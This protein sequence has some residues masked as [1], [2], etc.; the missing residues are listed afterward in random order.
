LLAG[1]RFLHLRI[2][3]SKAD[4]LCPLLPCWPSLSP[5][6][7]SEEGAGCLSCSHATALIGLTDAFVTI[8]G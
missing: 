2:S 1:G 4:S 7:F 8:E 3:S 5:I 6:I